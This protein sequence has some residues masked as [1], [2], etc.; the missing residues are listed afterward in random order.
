M[1]IEPSADVS[2]LSI[3]GKVVIVDDV[4]SDFTSVEDVVVVNC[5]VS[6]AD[7]L[8]DVVEAGVRG[9]VKL[10]SD[11]NESVTPVDIDDNAMFYSQ[12]QNPRFRIEN[13][14]PVP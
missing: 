1:Y 3:A 10:L 12:R 11:V 14:K 5:T 9:I 8:D 2:E 7:D 13:L 4:T 6:S